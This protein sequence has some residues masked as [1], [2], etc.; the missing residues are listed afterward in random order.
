M[1]QKNRIKIRKRTKNKNSYSSQ[2]RI[3]VKACGVSPDGGRE[4]A[5]GLGKFCETGMLPWMK[6]WWSYGWWKWWIRERRCDRRRKRWRV[7]YKETEIRLTVR[8]RELVLET[9]WS[10]SKGTI[11]YSHFE[12]EVEWPGGREKDS[13]ETCSLCEPMWVYY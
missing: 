6:E 9:T 3:R 7:R 8:S 2:D 5:D 11:S 4:S 13:D 1:E 12:D 10:T